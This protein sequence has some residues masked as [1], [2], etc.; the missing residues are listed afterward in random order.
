MKP[1]L[2]RILFA[3]SLVVFSLVSVG[4]SYA[5]DAGP[6]DAYENDDEKDRE[7]IYSEQFDQH[8]KAQTPALLKDSA[9]SIQ[10]VITQRPAKPAVENTKPESKQSSDDSI[11]SFN[12]LYYIIQKYKLQDIVD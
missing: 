9:A 4:Q 2:I 11:L 6:A 10:K 3:F 8:H 12:F 5:Q 1:K 7:P